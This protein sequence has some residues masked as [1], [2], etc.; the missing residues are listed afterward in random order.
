MARQT[1]R[2]VSRIALFAIIPLAIGG[3]AYIDRELNE[4]AQGAKSSTQSRAL[5]R[6]AR[7]EPTQNRS[8][9]GPSGDIQGK[10]ET[11]APAPLAPGPSESVQKAAPDPGTAPAAKPSHAP[12]PVV[13]PG[14]P[15]LSVPPAPA[16]PPASSP[17]AAAP[18]PAQSDQ[19]PT[20]P[21]PAPPRPEPQ[22]APPNRANISP[23]RQA[24]GGLVAA[25]RPEP[26]ETLTKAQ[27]AARLEHARRLLQRGK[28]IEAR[29]TLQTVVPSI[30]DAA[31]HELA[32]TYDP[33]YLGQLPA[34]DDGSEPRTA[35]S[36]YQDAINHGASAAGNDLDRLRASYPA[37]R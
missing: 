32:R 22:P 18:P 37:L 36:L 15:S 8:A 28:V 31:L 11:R 16:A 27:L 9:P 4:I 35:A 19:L 24:G 33:Y 3:C 17:P 29:T 5:N 26:V 12:T 30:P 20:E 14:S 7:A 23:S 1:M 25:L 34:I 13:V 10:S 2:A 6:V 21:S